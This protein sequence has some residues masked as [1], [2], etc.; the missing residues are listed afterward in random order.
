MRAQEWSPGWHQQDTIVQAPHERH[1]T[2][3]PAAGPHWYLLGAMDGQNLRAPSA[4]WA[5]PGPAWA[6]YNAGYLDG[7]SAAREE[8]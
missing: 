4:A 5:L 1:V 2:P 3:K 8:Q 6:A 7:L